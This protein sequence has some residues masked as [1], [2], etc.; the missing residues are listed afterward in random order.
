VARRLV[1]QGVVG[2]DRRLS[3]LVVRPD[4]VQKEVHRAQAADAV[5]D[6]DPTQRVELEVL[7]LIAIELEALGEISVGGQKEAAGTAGRV[8]DDLAR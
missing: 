4:A 8:Y 7:V 1:A 6:L 3:S 2:L 5:H